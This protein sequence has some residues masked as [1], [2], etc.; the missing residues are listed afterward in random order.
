MFGH[1]GNVLAEPWCCVSSRQPWALWPAAVPSAVSY[2]LLP[3]ACAS[4]P[5]DRCSAAATP[6]EVTLGTEFL[7]PSRQWEICAGVRRARL[8]RGPPC[9]SPPSVGHRACS[10]RAPSA[11]CRGSR[12]APLAARTAWC[13]T[14]GPRLF[15]LPS[16][17]VRGF[18][19]WCGFTEVETPL[20]LRS[21]T[22]GGISLPRID[23]SSLRCSTAWGRLVGFAIQ[24]FGLPRP[25]SWMLRATMGYST[26]LRRSSGYSA[27]SPRSGATL[28]M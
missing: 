3:K 4:L 9:G 12:G 17:R 15:P 26:S 13:W 6:T 11:A 20:A 28:A 21:F 7:T 10:F 19:S 16:S 25:K 8:R 14:F 5:R 24:L 2:R 23:W 1:C 18:R 22:T 27:T